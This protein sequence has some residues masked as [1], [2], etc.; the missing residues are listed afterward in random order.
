MNAPGEIDYLAQICL[1]DVGLITNIGPAHLEGVGSIEGVMHAKGELLGRIHSKG[2][3]ILNADDRRLRYLIEHV[4]VPALLL[5]GHTESAVIRAT[6]I[7][8][9]P[10]ETR[11]TLLFPNESI[12]VRMKIPGAFMVSNALAAAAVGYQLDI[13]ARQVKAALEAVV[14]VAGRMTISVIGD[15]LTVVDDTYNANP[16]SMAAAFSTLKTLRKKHRGIVILGD[17]FELGDHAPALHRQVG[18]LAAQ[19]GI[20]LLFAAGEHAESVAEG[21]RSAGMD[22]QQIF[23]G[24]KDQISQTALKH[25]RPLDWVLVKGSRGMAMENVVKTI[26]QWADQID[27]RQ[28]RER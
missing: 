18:A 21:A 15:R 19:S 11:F 10:Q 28:D 16:G 17:M 20:A 4:P 24:T 13:S 25:L 22:P 14:P 7:M 5:Y 26:R 1:P 3:A 6:Q 9:T 2:T 8:E 12:P 27:Q 23:T